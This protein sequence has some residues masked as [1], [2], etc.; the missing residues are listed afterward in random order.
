[1]SMQLDPDIEFK[2][3]FGQ[4]KAKPD[5]SSQ[6]SPTVPSTQPEDKAKPRKEQ[7]DASR[8]TT[9]ISIEQP[10]QEEAGEEA[11]SAD[12]QEELDSLFKQFQLVTLV[13]RKFCERNY[14]Q[15]AAHFS[16]LPM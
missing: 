14:P 8:K 3:D 16:D 2:M 13:E 11:A 10:K 12:D 15:A 9:H 6:P 4:Q 7:Q 5:Q 1:M